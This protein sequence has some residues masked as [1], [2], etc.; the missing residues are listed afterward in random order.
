MK[1]I[2]RALAKKQGFADCRFAK[3][4]QAAHAIEFF[5][6]LQTGNQGDMTWLS[7]DPVRRADPTRV[8]VEAKTILVLAANYFQ[9]PN[10]RRTSGKIA[11]Y[12]WGDDYHKIM[13]RNMGPIDAF[14]QENGG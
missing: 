7:R 6:W 13:L 9:G 12:A 5:S 10:P 14:L 1:T 3:A 8:L 11:R 2:L 4:I